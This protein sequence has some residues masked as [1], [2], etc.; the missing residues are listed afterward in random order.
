[1]A[2]GRCLDEIVK[3]PFERVATPDEA[4][5]RLARLYDDAAQALRGAVERFLKRGAAVGCDTRA[6][7]LSASC[8]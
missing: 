7:P 3:G 4:V 6:V 5:D 8:A 2:D 1:M